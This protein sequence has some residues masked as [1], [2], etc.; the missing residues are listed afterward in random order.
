VKDNARTKRDAHQT[1]PSE[2]RVSLVAAAS[3]TLHWMQLCVCVCV[4]VCGGGGAYLLAGPD[5]GYDL[6]PGRKLLDVSGEEGSQRVAVV[7]PVELRLIQPID[8]NKPRPFHLQLPLWRDR[9]HE[10][11]LRLTGSERPAYLCRAPPGGRGS[12]SGGRR[13][14]PGCRSA[15]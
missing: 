1:R 3:L 10:P 13:S 9:A 2:V 15:G 4:C 6:Q 14:D 12:P 8:Q 7:R 5:R 11:R